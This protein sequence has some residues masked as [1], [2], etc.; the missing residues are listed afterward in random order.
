MLLMLRLQHFK[1]APFDFYTFGTTRDKY[2]L[3]LFP[4][5]REAGEG[6]SQV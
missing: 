1:M 3:Q 6:L 4:P 5:R 2:N